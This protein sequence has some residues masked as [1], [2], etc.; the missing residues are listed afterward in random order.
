[1]EVAGGNS[2]TLAV[3]DLENGTRHTVLKCG[4]LSCS[5]C[6][7]IVAETGDDEWIGVCGVCGGLFGAC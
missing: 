2:A 3:G 5:V 4:K 1:M 6:I 7:F